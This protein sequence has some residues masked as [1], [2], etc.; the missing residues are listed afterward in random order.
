M[1]TNGVSSR[2]VEF[3]DPE[4]LD[5]VGLQTPF[6]RLAHQMQ[7]ILGD[8]GIL[9]EVVHEGEGPLVPKDASVSIHFSGFL[10]YADQPFES[11][12]RFKFPKMMK[13]GKDMTVW[14]LDLG[15]RTMQRGEFSRFLLKPSY[16]YGEMGCPPLIPPGATVLYEVQVIDYLDSAKVDE[17][18]ALLPE[19]QNLAP[20]SMLLNVVDT[21]RSFGN[22]CFNQS[23]YED[24]KHRYKQ[25][26]TL[27]RNREPE[28]EGESRRVEEASL[29]FLLNLSLVYLRLERPHKALQFGQK[30]LKISTANT[31]ALF[32]CGQ[33]C[34]EMNDYEKARDYLTTA[35]A[36][37]P[38]DTDINNLLQKLAKLRPGRDE[39]V[40]FHFILTS[41]AVDPE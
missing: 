23:R 16:A 3:L 12:R 32:R 38:Y 34:L 24:A 9:K 18:F 31:K 10:E 6:Q 21:E 7:D 41:H 29:P 1:P 11:T 37:K 13:L 35:Q 19:E 33:A 2:L 27:L 26:L 17:F 8:G 36:K 15:L 22:R 30:A 4:E 20:L 5:R 40:Y 28:D 14:G 25:A 39:T